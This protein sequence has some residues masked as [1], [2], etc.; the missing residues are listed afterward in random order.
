[1]NVKTKLVNLIASYIKRITFFRLAVLCTALLIIITLLVL[2]EFFRTDRYREFLLTFTA[3][4]PAPGDVI[5]THD[6]VYL[7]SVETERQRRN[8]ELRMLPVFVFQPA[9]LDEVRKKIE[10]FRQ[11]LSRRK[12]R[13]AG[14]ADAPLP[15]QVQPGQVQS[16]RV[17]S[18]RV[19]LEIFQPNELEY[20]ERSLPEDTLARILSGYAEEMLTDGYYRIPPGFNE[21]YPKG[22]LDVFVKADTPSR[23]ADISEV[24]TRE[25]FHDFFLR[26]AYNDK[27]PPDTARALLIAAYSFFEENVYFDGEATF[28]RLN[29]IREEVQPVLRTI[30]GNTILVSKGRI[31]SDQD[32]EKIRLL[33]F[34]RTGHA[35]RGVPGPIT[36][37]VLLIFIAMILMRPP[38]L[39]KGL[40]DRP[41]LFLA[42][43][44][45]LYFVSSILMYRFIALPEQ[46]PLA[47][48]LPTA[49]VTMLISVIIS[50]RAGVLNAVILALGQIL[51]PAV[52]PEAIAFVFFSGIIGTRVV[53]KADKRLA[54]L[55]AG[56]ILCLQQGLAAVVLSF[57]S[58]FGGYFFLGVV[59]ASALSGLVWGILNLTVLPLVERITRAATKFRLMELSDPDTPILKRMLNLAPGTYNHSISV[60]N[61]AETACREIG[62]N[63]LLARVGA[64]YHDIGKIDHA[65]YFIENQSGYNKHDE[66]NSGL[67]SAIIRSHVK[68]GVEQAGKLGLPDE[69]TDIIA[70]HHGGGFIRYFYQKAI[71]SKQKCVAEEDYLYTGSPPQSKE[72]AVVMLADSVEA[73]SRLFKKP[74]YATIEKAV[75][76]IFKEKMES[77][78]LDKAH[79]SLSEL[80]TTQKCFVKVLSGQFHSR[81]EYPAL[82]SPG[83]GA[84]KNG[85]STAPPHPG[86][87]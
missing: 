86:R 75:N 21:K 53:R 30:P 70:Q 6:L 74:T 42:C 38:M 84:S 41:F 48:I 54:L 9:I 17:Y 43:I 32:I 52:S 39:E 1:M 50:Y 63:A 55:N 58:G 67:S 78:Q 35:P 56:M 72:A 46:F 79:V 18:D 25:V 4:R 24:L 51:F 10:G 5:L 34:S 82:S 87:Q 31:V 61:L 28:E 49:L 68:I 13:G 76:G 19:Y 77:G 26:K 64:Y 37:L 73:V 8:R 2:T 14:G 81:I 69:V 27:I 44:H 29:K 45:T 11:F 15:G 60:G 83:E 23:L 80:S 12:A 85:A 59:V 65:E 3:G 22:L 40:G 7:D 47:V 71:E 20:I 16:D 33:A 57:L 36:Y 66:L 62:A